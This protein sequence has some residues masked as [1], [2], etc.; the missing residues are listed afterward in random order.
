MPSKRQQKRCLDGERRA[1]K[2]AEIRRHHGSHCYLCKTLAAA[3]ID[4]VI[5]LSQGGTNDV[6]NLR[7]CCGECNIHKSHVESYMADW[8]FKNPKLMPTAKQISRLRAT[9][10]YFLAI[11][12]RNVSNTNA[13]DQ[14]GT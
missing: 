3:T 14:I 12:R 7:M 11:T 8:K 2:V 9:W 10:Q 1:R 4:H 13:S 5:P 6:Q